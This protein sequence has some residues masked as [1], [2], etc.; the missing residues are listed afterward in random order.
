MGKS[1]KG[2]KT[3]QNLLKA[4]AGESQARQRYTLFADKARSEGYEQIAALFEETALN[5]QYH[6]RRFFSYLE[7]GPV[8]ITA[9][10][11]A[12]IVGTTMENLEEAAEGEYEEWAELYP[13]FAEVATEEGF[14]QVAAAFKVIV[15]VEKLH[16]KRYRKLLKNLGEEH[17][18]KKEEEVRWKCR[19]CGYVH[20]GKEAPKICPSCLEKQKE[21]ELEC[22][23][24]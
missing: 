3:E 16:E 14:P 17:V 13:G 22:A 5:E 6:A 23:N 9:T 15:E 7:G 8:E 20:E 10:Y 11:P 18:F 12:G 24:Y 4:F 21:F 1:I 19:K 2:T